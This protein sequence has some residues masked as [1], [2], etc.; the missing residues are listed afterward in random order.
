LYGTGQQNFSANDFIAAGYTSSDYQYF[1][2]I[3]DHELAHV[4]ALNATIIALGGSPVLACRYNFGVTNVSTY[5]KTAQT[6]ENLGVSAYDGALTGLTNPAL[7]QVAA[8]IA[9]GMY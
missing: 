7:Q 2:M 3:A 9:T 5:V 1:N 8:T 4:R 6:F